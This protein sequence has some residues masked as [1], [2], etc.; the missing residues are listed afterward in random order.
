[1]ELRSVVLSASL[2]IA[3]ISPVSAASEKQILFTMTTL[4]IAKQKCSNVEAN[5]KG[6]GWGLVVWLKRTDQEFIDS[7]SPVVSQLVD[8]ASQFPTFCDDVRGAYGP[9]GIPARTLPWA[10]PEFR[11]MLKLSNWTESP[12]PP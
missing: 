5:S 12:L 2:V 1:M 9:Q 6:A 7:Y 10:T 3:T 11:G 8:V 4:Y